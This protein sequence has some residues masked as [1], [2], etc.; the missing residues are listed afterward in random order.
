MRIGIDFD[1]TIADITTAAILY[2]REHWG[3]E[4]RPEQTWGASGIEVVGGRERYDQMFRDLHTTPLG[5]EVPPM[6]G[7]LD[8]LSRL[9]EEHE[10]HVVTARNEDEGEWARR[11]LERHG[12]TVA[13]VCCTSRAPKLDACRELRLSVLFDDFVDN[14]KHLGPSTAAAL[15]DAPYNRDLQREPHIRLVE[16]WHAFEALCGELVAGQG[17]GALRSAERTVNESSA[18][19]G[20]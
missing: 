20:S 18:S 10:I 5:L 1:G 4:L 14:F 11:W 6:P 8:V 12:L 16:H 9:A 15:L 17:S 7:A 2:G 13:G 19:V 3:V